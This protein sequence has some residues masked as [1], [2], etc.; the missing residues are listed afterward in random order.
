MDSVTP[1]DILKISKTLDDAL[2]HHRQWYDDVLRCLICHL[3]LSDDVIAIDAHHRCAFGTWFYGM[4]NKQVHELPAF[5]NIAQQHK[6][7][8]D[9]AREICLKFRA[10][11]KIDKVEYDACTHTIE[12]FREELNSL[13]QSV[14]ILSQEIKSMQKAEA[15]QKTKQEQAKHKNKAKRNKKPHK[16]PAAK[17]PDTAQDPKPK[18]AS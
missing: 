14:F 10:M 13:I 17:A 18:K 1:D 11:G 16:K 6:A 12:Q 2:L 15:A 7:M 3:P 4:G 8:H 5:K 9:C